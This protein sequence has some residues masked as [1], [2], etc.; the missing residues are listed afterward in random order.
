MEWILNDKQRIACIAIL[1]ALFLLGLVLFYYVSGPT[2]DIIAHYLNARSY[3]TDRFLSKE[4]FNNRGWEIQYNTFYI[5]PYREPIPAA[6]FVTL[7]MLFHNPVIPYLIVLFIIFVLALW[8]FGKS[9]DFDSLLLYGIMLNPFFLYLSFVFNGTEILS[10]SFM[11]IAIGLI[12]RKKPTAGLFMGLAGLSKYPTLIFLPMLFF[13]KDRKKIIT[14]FIFLILITMPWLVFN[15]IFYGNP[16]ESYIADFTFNVVQT[17]NFLAAIPISIPII[18]ILVSIGVPIL[19]LVVGLLFSGKKDIKKI[20]VDALKGKEFAKMSSVFLVLAFVGYLVVSLHTY[21]L[22]QLRYSYF[23]CA[24]SVFFTLIILQH[25]S[26]NDNRIKGKFIVTSIIILA[27][28]ITGYYYIIN[29]TYFAVYNINPPNSIV[30]SSIKE[31]NALGF[32]NC[33]VVS[34]AWIDLIY[35]NVSAYSPLA[36]ENATALKYPI[37]EFR[38]I[39]IPQAYILDT[40][41]AVTKYNNTEFSILF[42][43]NVTCVR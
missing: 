15:Y 34:N 38:N 24:T 12:Y 32:Q 31:L 37:V 43:R 41:N 8:Y 19:F 1:F 42:P 29:H 7:I 3:L 20:V 16:F 17:N 33:R 40:N 14:S 18:P 13:L 27:I 26:K 5:E 36:L 39:G 30:K 28:S 6:I 23:L 21:I 35:L 2:F 22:S 9:L 25:L 10:L 11:L 4:F